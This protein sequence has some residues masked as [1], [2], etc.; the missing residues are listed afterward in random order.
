MY[1]FDTY[2]INHYITLRKFFTI[3]FENLYNNYYALGLTTAETINPKYAESKT[4]ASKVN[5]Y[6]DKIKQN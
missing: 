2:H 1:I 3:V 6:I 4:W 5:Y